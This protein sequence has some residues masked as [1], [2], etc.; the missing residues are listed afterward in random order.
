MARNSC[1]RRLALFGFLATASIGCEPGRD[2]ATERPA[3]T[4][5]APGRAPD[6]AVSE[7]ASGDVQ[8]DVPSSP[9]H[10]SLEAVDELLIDPDSGAGRA[11]SPHPRI[12]PPDPLV[13]DVASERR[14][15]D[16]TPVEFYIVGDP[17]S[18]L[19]ALR[20]LRRT[21]P[22]EWMMFTSNNLLVVAYD[23]TGPVVRLR[24]RAQSRAFRSGAY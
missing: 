8:T 18:S 11:R 6:A 2:R 16:G 20:E 14:W 15:V 9:F 10:W 4:R 17:V 1:L 22:A 24:E 12:A 23:S 21:A 3:D 5:L 13:A 19:R 7:G